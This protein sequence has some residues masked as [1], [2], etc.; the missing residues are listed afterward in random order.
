ME[1]KLSDNK[2]KICS[3]QGDEHKI[4]LPEFL[5]RLGVD[6]SGLSEQEASRRLKECGSNVLEE[7]GKEGILSKYIRQFRNLFS[8]LLTIGALLSFLGEYLEPGQGNLYIG[9]ALAGVVILN[10]T[11]TFVQEYQ[12]AKT[13]ES[14]RQLLPPRAKVLREGKIR[15][16]LAS[17]LVVG[18]IIL[19][20]EGDKVPTD[21]RLIETN[22]LK[23]DHSNI[24]GEAEPQLRSLECTNSNM[25]ECRNMV[26]SG[27]LVQSGNGK[28]V[29]FG[30]GK[31]TQIGNLAI[32]TEKIS[33]V[34]TP[35]RRELNRFIKVISTIA[36]FMGVT[37]FILAFLL[38]DTFFAS[39]IFAI[40]IIVANVPEGL[41]PTVTLALSLAS[42]RMAS[43]NALIKNLE[44]V[45]T[46]GSTTVI[47]TDKTGTLTQNRMAV[48]S[49]IVGF[50]SL[51]P[52]A[53]SGPEKRIAELEAE[54]STK[55]GIAGKV[56]G[57]GAKRVYVVESPIWD[58]KK[59]PSA[60]IRVAGLCN[61]AKIQELPA[62]YTGDPTE[63]ALLVFANSLEDVKKLQN[64][65]PRLKEFPFDSLT[66][67]MEVICRTPEGKLEIYLKGAPEVVVKMCGSVIDS[68][69]VRKLTENEKKE[70]LDRHLRLAERGERVIALAYRQVEEQKEYAEDFIFLG[71]IGIVDPPRPEAREAITKCHAAGIKVVMITGDH[72][73][74]AEAIAKKV[75]L[76][77]SGNLEI[78]TG[79]ELNLLSRTDLASRLKNPSIVFA[80]TS[81]V[82]KLKI[83]QLFQAEGEIVTMTGDGVNDAPAIKN[84]DMGVAMGSGTDVAREAADMVLLDDNFAT[85]VNAIEEGRTVFDNIKKFI[86][87]II[88]HTIPEVLPYIAFIFFA[89]PLPMPVQLILAIDLGTDMLPAIALGEEKGEE[90]IMKRPPRARD[91]KLLTPQVLLTAYGIKG[92]IE[93]VAG[94][95]C[96]FAVL[97]E[98]GWKFGEQLANNNPLYMQAI[99]AFF[100]AVIICQIANVFASRTRFQSVFTMGLFSNRAILLGIA[101]ELLIL[102]LIIWS[103]F[104]NLIFNT[105]PLDLRYVLLS[106]PFAIC[107]LGIDELRKYLL[108]RKVRWAVRFLKW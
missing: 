22:S 104:A 52:E 11:F 89:L 37:F 29:V 82:Q 91:E 59:V 64:D 23:V 68:G 12:A 24:T 77:D 10:G 26:F 17:E 44:S 90:D 57:S 78:I 4:P 49:L 46:L 6:E 107:L 76:V 27:T 32:L 30:I 92:P 15:E 43:R 106:V 51:V 67:R 86:V 103:P 66:K 38:H 99:T 34:E 85:I 70:I 56:M 87:Y 9:I 42:K 55:Q 94:F 97:F 7:T 101:I 28:A 8:I 58:P 33:S 20:E 1:K 16:I 88:T 69:E 36:I 14:F 73:V 53:H 71:F 108:R 54:E 96:Y 40:G 80:R 2:S 79:D 75:G 83:V 45:E 35:I 18:D 105:S 74:T 95:F 31:N 72:P 62:G 84:A 61:N 98:G 47:C 21:G 39:L 100:S 25:L 5:L 50:E 60:L 13:M 19:L 81:P 65:Y 102:A 3:P 63:G 41:L 48:N 93:A